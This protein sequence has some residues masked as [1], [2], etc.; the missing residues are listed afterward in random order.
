MAVNREITLFVKGFPVGI[1]ASEVAGFFWDKMGLTI[2][3]ERINVKDHTIVA[4]AYLHITDVAMAKFLNLQIHDQMAGCTLSVDPFKLRDERTPREITARLFEERGSIQQ[5]N[6][7][8]IP[9]L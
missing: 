1:T 6:R 2:S 4:S 8:G 3:P 5:T 9:K 7:N